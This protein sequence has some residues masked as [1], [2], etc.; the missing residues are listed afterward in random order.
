MNQMF[1]FAAKHNVRPKVKYC[2]CWVWVNR[3]VICYEIHDAHDVLFDCLICDVC[4]QIEV[5]KLK[6]NEPQKAN[7]VV[8]KVAKNAARYRMVMEYDNSA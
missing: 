8:T 1:A 2:Y 7:E 3:I 4:A 6:W 5:L